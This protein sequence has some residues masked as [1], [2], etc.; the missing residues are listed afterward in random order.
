MGLYSYKEL[1]ELLAGEKEG[2][3]L[4]S[5]DIK[6]LEMGTYHLGHK[7]ED[8]AEWILPRGTHDAI[9]G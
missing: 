7:H 2:A 5:A 8:T 6:A 1:I 3:E 9:S 4:F